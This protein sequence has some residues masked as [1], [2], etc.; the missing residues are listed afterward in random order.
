MIA[1]IIFSHDC[2][3]KNT[4]SSKKNIHTYPKITLLKIL[5]AYFRILM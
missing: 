3:I 5:F 4:K 2:Y 1:L